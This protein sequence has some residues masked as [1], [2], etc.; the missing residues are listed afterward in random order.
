MA[1]RRFPKRALDLLLSV[2]ALIVLAPILAAI[3]VA[4]RLNR[5]EPRSSGT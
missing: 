1:D 5:T 2:L 4:I 3:V